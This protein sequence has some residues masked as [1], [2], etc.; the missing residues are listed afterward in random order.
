MAHFAKLD[1]NNNVIQVEVVNNEVITDSDGNE[2]ES[3]G[4]AFL[5]N[6]YNEPNAVW[7]K[8]SYNT[9]GNIYYTPGG[10]FTSADVDPDQTKKFRGNYAVIGGK[11]DATNDVFIDEQHYPSWELDTSSWLWEAPNPPGR[12]PD[13]GKSYRWDEDAYQADNSTGWVENTND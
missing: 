13:D 10:N 12:K 8:T 11:Y 2:Q 5:R 6:L 7:K 3:L 9:V 4:V 1:S